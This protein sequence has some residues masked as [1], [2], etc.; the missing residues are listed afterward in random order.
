MTLFCFIVLCCGWGK[1]RVAG[2]EGDG[3]GDGDVDVDADAWMDGY[4]AN[5]VYAV[6][7]SISYAHSIAGLVCPYM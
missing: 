1:A 7:R 5:E 2:V 4:P 6:L 3:D